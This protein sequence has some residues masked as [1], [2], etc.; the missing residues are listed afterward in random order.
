M[1]DSSFFLLGATVVFC[2]CSDLRRRRRRHRRRLIPSQ[3]E[4][5]N[6]VD[7]ASR[8]NAVEG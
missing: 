8:E 7:S 1:T 6:S 4:R 2:V 3:R 5:T